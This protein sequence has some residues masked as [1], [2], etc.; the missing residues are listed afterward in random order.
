MKVLDKD[1]EV[2][3]QTGENH[4]GKRPNTPVRFLTATTIIGD[5]VYDKHDQSIGDVKDIMLNLEDG[6]IEYVV[7]EFGGFL[8]IGEK[9]F[10][11]PFKALQL[12]TD[13]HAFI[14]DQT[15][16]VL[17]NAPGFDKD[18]WPET[19]SHAMRSSSTYWG[20]FMG[21]NTGSVPY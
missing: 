18:H 14:L 19:N 10:A 12:D 3:N 6:T 11:V 2:E 15:R 7:I 16:D 5:K 13:R 4:T 20:G 9:F 1:L 21:P 17:E 8:G